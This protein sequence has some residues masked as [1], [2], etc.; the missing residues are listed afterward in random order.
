[1]QVDDHI[2][3]DCCTLLAALRSGEALDRLPLDTPLVPLGSL[4]RSINMIDIDNLPNPEKSRKFLETRR[5]EAL[6]NLV[7]NWMNSTRFNELRL[8][9]GLIF[10][11]EWINDPLKTRSEILELVTHIP[12]DQWWNLQSFIQSVKE[13][14]PDFKRPAGDYDSW[15]IRRKESQE[16][17][18]GFAS[19]NE[20]E[21][22]LIRFIIC[23]PLHWLGFLDLASAGEDKPILAFRP[24]R[25]SEKLGQAIPPDDIPRR[26]SRFRYLP[27]A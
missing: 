2:L 13:N 26:T 27:T 10:E 12:T 18:R 15:F 7:F 25:W 11:G 9:P 14:K 22:E 17:L 3:D 8:L 20:V 24:S 6:A 19:W 1:M 23:G 16:Y 5:P 21:G 4:L